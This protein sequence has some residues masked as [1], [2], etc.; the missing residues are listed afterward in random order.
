MTPA[1]RSSKSTKPTSMPSMAPERRAL[2]RSGFATAG[3]AATLAAGGL[4]L[5]SPAPAQTA[6]ARQHAQT[7]HIRLAATADTV[8][9]GYFSKLLKPQAEINS[10]DYAIIETLTHHAGDDRERMIDGDPGAESVYFWTKGQKGVSRRGTGPMD[11]AT[12]TGGGLGVH[13][14]TGRSP[15]AAQSRATC[16]RYASST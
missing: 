8:H 3:G 16:W 10:G 5:V 13:I 7:S 1:A 6:A 11:A 2:L 12:G 14:C 15:G 9:W 4:S